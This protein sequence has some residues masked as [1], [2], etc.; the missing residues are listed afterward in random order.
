MTGTAAPH[1]TTSVLPPPT[2]NDSDPPGPKRPR[3]GPDRTRLSF[4]PATGRQAGI[5]GGWW[6]RSRDAAAE[7]PGLI[8]ELTGLAGRVRR[9][10]LQADAFSNIPHRLDI[11][12]RKVA[13]AWFRYMNK[14][15]V[16]LTMASRDDLVLLVVPPRASQEAATEALR[17]AASGRRAGPPEAILAAAGIA[18]GGGQGGAMNNWPADDLDGTEAQAAD[19][20]ALARLDDDGAQDAGVLPRS[21][22]AREADGNVEA[23]GGDGGGVHGAAVHSGD[24]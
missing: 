3:R 8:A 6:P 14:H 15:T 10:A 12:G 23:S 7:L 2:A 1:G 4:D 18:V 9:V 24:R 21:Q 13:V 19:L 5:H 20:L 17:L 11:G 22:S 16:I